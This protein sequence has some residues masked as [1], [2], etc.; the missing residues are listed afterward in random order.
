MITN[1]AEL[2][3][4]LNKDRFALG[5]TRKRPRVIGDEIWKYEII[6]RKLEYYTNSKGHWGRRNI[7]FYYYKLRHHLL[8]TKYNFQIPPNVFDAGLRINHI[9]TIVVNPRARIGKWCDIHVCV[10]IGQDVEG[11]VPTMGD[12][13]YIGPGAKIFGGITVGNSVMIGA[14]AVVNKSFENDDIVIAGVPAK[15]KAEKKNPLARAEKYL[16]RNV[17]ELN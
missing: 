6:L 7:L 3:E 10:N 4:Y 16:T 9:G 11:N 15:I 17:F 14:N 8:S 2:K 13:V 5:I 12:D 1:K